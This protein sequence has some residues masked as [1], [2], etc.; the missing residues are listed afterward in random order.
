MQN[1]NKMNAD[2][3]KNHLINSGV[4]EA[5]AV[6]IEGKFF[7]FKRRHFRI[8]KDFCFSKLMLEYLD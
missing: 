7:I 5:Y 3:L 4:P 1:T 8:Q 6:K 2:Q